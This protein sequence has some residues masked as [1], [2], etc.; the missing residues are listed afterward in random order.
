MK[1]GSGIF[2][3][4][5]LATLTQVYGEPAGETPCTIALPFGSLVAT[6]LP[7]FLSFPLWGQ[8]T[9]KTAGPTA[10]AT[11]TPTPPATKSLLTLSICDATGT[12]FFPS[13]CIPSAHLA[14]RQMN[15]PLGT[16]A[17]ETYVNIQTVSLEMSSEI[18]SSGLSISNKAEEF[19]LGGLDFGSEILAS[20][21]DGETSVVFWAAASEIT[22]PSQE[23]D[24]QKADGNVEIQTPS[25]SSWTQESKTSEN[26]EIQTPSILPWTQEAK[27]SQSIEIQL[28]SASS[29]A[30]ESK[31]S[32]NVD[33]PQASSA[34][35]WAQESK[36]NEGIV[37]PQMPGVEMCTSG[38]LRCTNDMSFDT[39]V[40]GKWGTVR[41]CPPGT[42]CISVPSDSIACA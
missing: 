36:A 9:A 38:M 30:Q 31:P 15:D 10:T 11:P 8:K 32:E 19:W 16:S 33:E 14:K 1:I 18:S 42:K 25:K 26:V 39:C 7:F 23:S 6:R 24:S 27:P 34:P 35:S 22:E 5:L 29:W 37:L 20:S 41:N 17:A 28:S 3:C 12:E 21:A 13:D 40:H 2:L 4:G